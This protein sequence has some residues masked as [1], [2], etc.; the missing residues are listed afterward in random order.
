MDE[1]IKL[2]YQGLYD[3]FGISPESVKARDKHQQEK[4]FLI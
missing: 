2:L 4:G 1:K 3:K